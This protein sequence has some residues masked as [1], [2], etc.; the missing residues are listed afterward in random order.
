MTQPRWGRQ[1]I[2]DVFPRVAAKRGNRWAIWRS[3][4][5]QQTVAA[6]FDFRFA[7]LL[8]PNR[9]SKIENQK[10][11][12]ENNTFGLNDVGRLG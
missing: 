9:K 10:S 2:G 6:I 4:A 7:I 3:A 12:Q 1:S 5:K 8:S 11:A